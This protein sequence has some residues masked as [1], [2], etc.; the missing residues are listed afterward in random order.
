MAT[1]IKVSGDIEAVF[2]ADATQGFTLDEMYALLDCQYVER[3]ITSN[4]RDLWYDEE[5]KMRGAAVNVVATNM[6]ARAGGI[7]GDVIVGDA[8]LTEE[9]EVK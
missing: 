9:G 8:L 5:G 6:L 2:P 1:L 3:I 7:P 4:E